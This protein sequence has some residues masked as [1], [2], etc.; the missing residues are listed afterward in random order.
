MT[1]NQLEKIKCFL[2]ALQKHGLI[3]DYPVCSEYAENYFRLNYMDWVDSLEVL[4]CIQENELVSEDEYKNIE[5]KIEEFCDDFYPFLEKVATREL[6]LSQ[7]TMK[8]YLELFLEGNKK[9]KN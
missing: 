4:C 5:K 1:E 2:L 8:I 6:G 3:N 9:W 7:E